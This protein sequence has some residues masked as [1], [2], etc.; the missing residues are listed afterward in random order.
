M[1][2]WRMRPCCC[3]QGKWRFFLTEK[4]RTSALFDIVVDYTYALDTFDDYDYQ[5]LRLTGTTQEN[6]FHATYKENS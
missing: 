3:L 2:G 5:R 1:C 6:K 4:N